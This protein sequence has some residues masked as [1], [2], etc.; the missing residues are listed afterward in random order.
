MSA[1]TE[2]KYGKLLA[3]A[4]LIGKKKFPLSQFPFKN[5]LV[6]GVLRKM[7]VIEKHDDGMY[8]VGDGIRKATG[9]SIAAMVAGSWDRKP[10]AKKSVREKAAKP[11][12]D[13]PKIEVELMKAN[14]RLAN[15]E[16]FLFRIV[17]E[18]KVVV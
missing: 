12:E 18:G 7:N 8:S 17:N 13:S 16:S 10:A 11:I 3:K 15:I 14:G 9:E 1:D 5:R 2:S 6:I 4:K